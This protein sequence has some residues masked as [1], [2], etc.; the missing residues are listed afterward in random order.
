MPGF[1][2]ND[3]PKREKNEPTKIKINE[4]S[5]KRKKK[6]GNTTG[7]GTGSGLGKRPTNNKH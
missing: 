6:K 1:V 2:N 4:D 7:D 3:S 5:Q